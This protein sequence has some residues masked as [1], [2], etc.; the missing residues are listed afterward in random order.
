MYNMN[1]LFMQKH[2]KNAARLPRF[3]TQQSPPSLVTTHYTIET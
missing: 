1:T 3:C 2:T